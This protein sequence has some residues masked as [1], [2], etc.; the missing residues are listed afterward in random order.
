MKRFFSLYF[1]SFFQDSPIFLHI[2]KKPKKKR[3]FSD[4]LSKSELF[5]DEFCFV[6][7]SLSLL[8]LGL[9]G[10][11]SPRFV[12][13]WSLFSFSFSLVSRFRL[14]SLSHNKK[15]GKLF[16]RCEQRISLFIKEKEVF[17]LKR[18]KRQTKLN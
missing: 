14:V 15:Q 2:K 9:R 4:F 10:F 6:L 11:F 16:F 17:I 7:S 1:F 13:G 12:R 3:H 18:K 5:R 8:S